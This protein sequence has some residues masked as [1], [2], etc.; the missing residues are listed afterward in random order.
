MPAV[1]SIRGVLPADRAQRGL[2]ACM[3]LGGGQH[4][5]SKDTNVSV[6]NFTRAIGNAAR[7]ALV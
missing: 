1:G 2:R 3:V 7:P 6:A 5:R 4:F